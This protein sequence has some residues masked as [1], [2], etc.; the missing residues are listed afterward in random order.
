MLLPLLLNNMMSEAGE[1]AAAGD[2]MGIAR[3]GHGAGLPKKKRKPKEEAP[4]WWT[5]EWIV[6]GIEPGPEPTPAEAP[7]LPK[8]AAKPGIVLA[9]DTLKA[10]GEALRAEVRLSKAETRWL[11]SRLRTLGLAVAKARLI[12]QRRKVQARLVRFRERLKTLQSEAIARE[13]ARLAHITR[14]ARD[15]DEFMT[16]LRLV[17]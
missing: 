6:P 16:I 7:A 17:V 5:G 9:M 11:A 14:I 1:E 13:Q 2:A 3:R 4:P 8:I 10:E 15:D 12:E